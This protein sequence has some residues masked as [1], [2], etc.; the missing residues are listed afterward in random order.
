MTRHVITIGA[1]EHERFAPHSWDGQLGQTVPFKV[2]GRHVADATVIAAEVA[3]DGAEVTL[4]VEVP[5]P[6]GMDAAAIT[7]PPYRFSFRVP[8]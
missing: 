5:D 1:A 3:E 7:D 2:E 6:P 8:G 4:T